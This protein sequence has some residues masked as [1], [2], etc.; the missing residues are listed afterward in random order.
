MCATKRSLTFSISAQAECGETG[1]LVYFCRTPRLIFSVPVGMFLC[2]SWL[3][4]KPSRLIIQSALL[5]VS[6]YSAWI[7]NVSGW[8]YLAL[9]Y[10]LTHNNFSLTSYSAR[11]LVIILDFTQR[12][13]AHKAILYLAYSLASRTLDNIG[14]DALPS[15]HTWS[16]KFGYYPLPWTDDTFTESPP[17]WF[18]SV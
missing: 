13:L 18:Y 4:K 8:G 2:F 14:H 3:H 10:S 6:T 15:P 5:C 12:H 11:F 7:G 9:S 16:L 17:I 1:V